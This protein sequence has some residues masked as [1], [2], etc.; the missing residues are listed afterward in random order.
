VFNCGA[1]AA[2]ETSDLFL[3]QFFKC[4]QFRIRIQMDQ[5]IISNYIQKQLRPKKNNKFYLR[6]THKQM[7]LGK[8]TYGVDENP[9]WTLFHENQQ[10]SDGRAP[11]LI[12]IN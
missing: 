6:P 5:K 1:G 2:F 12:S 7:Q 11:N 10:I 4:D 9:F 8:I 3:R